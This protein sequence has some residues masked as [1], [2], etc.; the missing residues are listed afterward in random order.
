MSI[1]LM[2]YLYV[3]VS[4]T[5]GT[6]GATCDVGCG[7]R[8]LDLSLAADV[9]KANPEGDIQGDFRWLG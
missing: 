9:G 4:L 3:I 6:Y 7:F 8:S 2:I 1:G 5:C